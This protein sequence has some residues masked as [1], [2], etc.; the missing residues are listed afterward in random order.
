VLREYHLSEAI[1][2]DVVSTASKLQ[3]SLHN[4]RAVDQFISVLNETN[5]MYLLA[6]N[7]FAVLT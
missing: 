3:L 4:D 5:K 2:F 6:G 1:Q 7:R